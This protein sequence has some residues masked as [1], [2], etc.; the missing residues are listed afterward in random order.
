MRNKL[1]YRTI[2]KRKLK[3]KLSI[4]NRLYLI[5][6]SKNNKFKINL[7]EVQ[8]F[9]KNLKDNNMIIRINNNIIKI[10][11]VHTDKSI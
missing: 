9:N 5:I 7:L 3:N 4:N 1:N 11:Q 2:K 8:G 6:A 10:S